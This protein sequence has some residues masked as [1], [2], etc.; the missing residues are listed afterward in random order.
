MKR[1]NYDDVLDA[2]NSLVENKKAVKQK[3]T[4]ESRDLLLKHTKD[5]FSEVEDLIR[6]KVATYELLIRSFTAYKVKIRAIDPGANIITR[7]NIEESG[8]EKIESINSVKIIWSSSYAAKNNIDRE[9]TIDHFD[10]ILRG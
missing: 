4:D 5:Y 3:V 6:G 8:D 9:I 1:K 7:W 2:I 10:C